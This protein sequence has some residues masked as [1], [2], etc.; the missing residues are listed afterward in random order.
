MSIPARSPAARADSVLW[1]ALV[2]M[3]LVH[4]VVRDPWVDRIGVALA[5][6]RVGVWVYRIVRWA[7]LR[8][9]MG[10]LTR[11]ARKVSEHAREAVTDV[12]PGHGLTDRER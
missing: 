3:F 4:V 7:V 10:S 8:V 2:V 6:A 1:L 5:C 9:R 12:A 11:Q